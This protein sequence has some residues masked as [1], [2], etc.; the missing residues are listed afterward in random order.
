MFMQQL[1][2]VVNLSLPLVFLYQIFPYFV[3]SLHGMVFC[4][5]LMGLYAYWLGRNNTYK[6]VKSLKCTPSGIQ[7]QEFAALVNACQVDTSRVNLFYAYTQEA[8]AFAAFDTIIIDPVV[9]HSVDQ[10]EN[11]Q[12]VCAVF[13]ASIEPQ[14]NEHQKTRLSAIKAALTPGAQRFIFRHELGHVVHKFSYKKLF[15]IFVSAIIAAFFGLLAAR[16]LMNIS[17]LLALIVG[18]VIGGV[19]DVL[20]TFASN[21]LFKMREEKCA[22]EFAMRYSSEQ[23]IKEAADF[24]ER[25]QVIVDEHKDK[26]S[27]WALLPSEITTGHPNGFVRASFLRTN[28]AQDGS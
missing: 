27:L 19:S 9:W 26:K 24:F 28:V 22:D 18:M 8:I 11:A 3:L 13:S 14:L 17:G 1:V 16:A 4:A 15:V 5:F 2:G 23:D 7:L 12:K 6:L 21:L 25:H 10:D 20:L